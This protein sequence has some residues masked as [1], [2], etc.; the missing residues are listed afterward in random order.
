MDT[1]CTLESRCLDLARQLSS[2]YSKCAPPFHFK[3]LLEHFGISGVRERP[4]DRD[5]CLRLERGRLFIDVNAMY[6]CT[7]RR[8]SI[9]HEIGHLI[10]NACSH[11]DALGPYSGEPHVE[12]LCNRI[13]GSL[14]VPDRTLREYFDREQTIENWQDRIR[15]S[16]VIAAAF[17]FGVSVDAL[18]SRAFHDLNMAP[19]V[20]AIVWRHAENVG[21]PSS[22]KAI[23]VSSAWHR[24]AKTYIPRNK[25]V[26]PGS[27]IARAFERR[28][29]VWATE[30]LSLGALRG[31]FSVEA[32]GFG[33]GSHRPAGG[34][35][36]AALSLLRPMSGGPASGNACN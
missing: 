20:V 15:C 28:E 4:L 19:G 26:S 10:V 31:I 21:K 3:S 35:Y 13:A 2:G 22:E 16:T 5:A 14:L 18:A 33:S 1:D 17:A 23:R 32:Q 9:A 25:T 6:S 27:V 36:G 8:L 7:R 34:V 30:A 12:S 24:I 29:G 11:G